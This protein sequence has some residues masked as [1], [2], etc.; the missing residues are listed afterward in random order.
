[1][2]WK[3]VTTGLRIKVTLAIL[4]PLLL[5][6]GVFTSIEYER[7]RQ[8]VLANLSIMAGQTSRVIESSLRHAMLQSDFEEVQAVLDSIGQSEEFNVVF[9]LNPSGEIIFAPGESNVGQQLNNTHPDC[10]PCHRLPAD[11]RPQSV[12]VQPEGQ[13]R[14]FRS[15]QPIEN[16]PECAEC[17]SP[18]QRLLGLLLTDISMASMEHILAANLR[19]NILWWLVTIATSIVVVN[20][21][22]NRFVLNRLEKLAAAVVG[23]GEGTGTPVVPEEQPDEIGRLAGAFNMMAQR[24]RAREQDNHKLAERLQHQSTQRGE[25]YRRVLSIQED[26]RK[27]VARELHDGLGQLLTGLAY[28]TEA[29]ERL[30][31]EDPTRA[32][33][34]AR[35]VRSLVAQTAQQMYELI[36]DLRPSALDDLGLVAALRATA[37]RLFE[38][39]DILFDI[40]SGHFSRMPP[41]VETTLY[42]VFQEGLNNVVRH[43]QASRVRISL[44]QIDDVFVGRIVDNGIG[45]KPDSISMTGQ[46]Q[47]GFGL[48]GMQERVTQCGGTIDIRSRPGLGTRIVVQVPLKGDGFG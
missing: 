45:F 27:R 31:A 25:L 35:V 41:L 30:V 22:L 48:L 29:I 6:L 3:A 14:V 19:E 40:R 5:V 28:Q 38:G 15:M 39:R 4:V 1:M 33:Q 16:R 18:D 37:E 47:H 32:R 44:G 10:Q 2:S 9:L 7:H 43:A 34:Q 42:R 26:E 21:V 11:E 46:D 36:F 17:H 13:E 23:L 12:I 8:G 20:V 24:V